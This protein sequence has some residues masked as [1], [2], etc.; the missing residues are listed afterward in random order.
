M[1]YISDSDKS[2]GTPNQQNHIPN[3]DIVPL[4]IQSRSMGS[5]YQ[6]I[7]PDENDVYLHWVSW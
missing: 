2:S 4:Q 5:S 6:G 1:D 7:W 3:C